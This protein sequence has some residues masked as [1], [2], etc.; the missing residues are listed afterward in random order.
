MH[1]MWFDAVSNFIGSSHG[2]F[3]FDSPDSNWKDF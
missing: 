2:E 1:V 3:L